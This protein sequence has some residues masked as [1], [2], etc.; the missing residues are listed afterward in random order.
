MASLLWSHLTCA[1]PHPLQLQSRKTSPFRVATAN[2]SACKC[3]KQSGCPQRGRLS[4]ATAM[5]TRGRARFLPTGFFPLS[6]RCTRNQPAFF[7]KLKDDISR[8]HGAGVS[9]LFPLE[10]SRRTPP[11]KAR[12][13]C[14]IESSGF[15][16][17]ANLSQ[18]GNPGQSK[19][20]D[21]RRSSPVTRA[22]N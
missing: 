6:S 22:F 10:T 3:G 2:T 7:N 21:P 18:A 12:S 16:A 15:W 1:S 9:S 20:S 8:S 19:C 11:V 17:Q 4:A 14:G 5:P 13:T